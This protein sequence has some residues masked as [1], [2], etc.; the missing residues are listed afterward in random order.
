MKTHDFTATFQEGIVSQI[1]AKQHLVKVHIPALEDFETAW[2]P[3]ITPNAGGNQF[4]CL[5]DVGELVAVILDARGEAGVVLG[6]MYNDEDTP[7][8]QNAQIWMKKFS[9]GTVISHDRSTGNVIVQTSGTI[10]ATAPQVI[11]NGNVQINGS[12]SVSDGANV[13]GS[14][15]ATGDVV[16]QGVSLAGHTHQGDSGGSTSEPR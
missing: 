9:N 7:P 14:I 1:D 5:P 16:G 11:I 10:T 4:Y 8:T 2:L 6:A 12:L 15:Q 13:N 3:M